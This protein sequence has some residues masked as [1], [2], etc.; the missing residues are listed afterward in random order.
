M[1]RTRTRTFAEPNRPGERR[2]RVDRA[3]MACNYFQSFRPPSEESEFRRDARSWPNHGKQSRRA[4][5][6]GKSKQTQ[7]IFKPNQTIQFLIVMS[8][9]TARTPG[10]RRSSAVSSGRAVRN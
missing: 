3:N 7:E 4:R 1:V 6:P 10:W 8:G 2:S 9:K 5:A